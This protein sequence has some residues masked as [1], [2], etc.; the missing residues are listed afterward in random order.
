MHKKSLILSVF[1]LLTLLIPHSP[2]YAYDPKEASQDWHKINTAYCDM[3][4]HP[5][6]DINRINRKIDIDF[7]DISID[8]DDYPYA[9]TEEERRLASKLDSIFKKAEKI[10]DMYPRKIH[11]NVKIFK[12]QSQLDDEYERIFGLPNRESRIS[13]Y[14]H[15]YTTIYTTEEVIREGVIAHEMGHA[16]SDHYFL[17]PPPEHIK[18]VMAQYVEV[19]LS[20]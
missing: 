6:A 14:V 7:Y 3:L 11:V 12:T 16:I 2:C 8:K 10:L 9:G 13:F 17:I 15:K 18:E 4:I 1:I 5:D 19:H 20:D